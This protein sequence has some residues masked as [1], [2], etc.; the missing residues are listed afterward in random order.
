MA[1]TQ[2]GTPA[3]SPARPIAR[4]PAVGIKKLV[5]GDEPID[6][7][8]ATLT[9]L[10]KLPGVGPAPAARIIERR[11]VKPFDSVDELRRVKGIGAKILEGMRPVVTVRGQQG[12][13]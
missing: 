7:N 8:R 5:P 12:G 13:S 9:E 1:S 11:E 3:N 6:V 10:Q 4:V 2:T